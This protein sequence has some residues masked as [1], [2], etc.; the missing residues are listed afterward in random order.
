MR[1]LFGEVTALIYPLAKMGTKEKMMNIYEFF[2]SKDIAEH[3]RKI[4]HQFTAI[5]M[6]Y[7]IWFSDYHS[8]REK[9]EAWQYLI[10][11][12]PDEQL[13]KG[14]WGNEDGSLVRSERSLHKYLEHY[15]Q[16]ENDFIEQFKLTRLG[17]IYDY[18]TMRI[19]DD[20]YSADE[21]F[22]D[23]YEACYAALS[24]DF[25]ENITAAR[26]TRRRLYS[27]PRESGW[28]EDTIYI[29]KNNE[30][31]QIKSYALDD[32]WAIKDGFSNMYFHIPTPFQ[33]GDLVVCNS[34]HGEKHTPFVLTH[35]PYWEKDER[36]RDMTWYTKQLAEAGGDWTDMQT[37]IYNVDDNGDIYWDHGP[38]YVF[39]EYYTQEL[40]EQEKILRPLSNFIKN[41]IGLE[42]FLTAYNIIRS[43][44]Y[45]D[46]LRV[47]YADI[48]E[49]K[50]KCGLL[51]GFNK[52]SD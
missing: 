23:S 22:Y 13:P 38:N 40:D 11:N 26:I 7:I 20:D 14:K 34:V 36:G 42:D 12:Y 6:A 5:E 43:E 17:Y 35:I 37:S 48:D 51:E 8:L 3:C 25:D 45:S 50:Y 16:I 10:D 9:H 29:N 21:V 15:I 31:I 24:D 47:Y 19:C 49:L 32:D 33:C 18:G 39:L 52:K 1:N 44:K 46:A 4:G 28:D 41:E 27:Q 30:V 2:N